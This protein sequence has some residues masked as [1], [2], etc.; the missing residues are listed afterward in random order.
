MLARYGK[1][2]ATLIATG[3]EHATTILSLHAQ[4][5]S[6]LVDSLSVVGLECSF[7]FAYGF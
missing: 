6:M 1:F 3:C 5:E 7:H 4:T 2:L